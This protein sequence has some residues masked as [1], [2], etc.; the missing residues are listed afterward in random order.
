VKENVGSRRRGGHPALERNA[1]RVVRDKQAWSRVDGVTRGRDGILMDVGGTMRGIAP[2]LGIAAGV[3]AVGAAA[4][5]AAVRGAGE[6]NGG[7]VAT[8]AGM[9]GGSALIGGSLLGVVATPIAERFAKQSLKGP[10]GLLL[11]PAAIAGAAVGGA[12]ARRGLARTHADEYRAGEAATDATVAETQ[13]MFRRAGASEDAIA[14]VPT[15]YDRSFFNAQYSPPL[16]PFGKSITVG[17][18]PENG[19]TLAIND[20]IAHEFSH[21]VVDAYAPGMTRSVTGDGKAM[22]E[23]LADTFSMAV[24]TDDWLQGEDSW[25]GGVRSFSNPEERGSVGMDGTVKPAPITRA[26][27]DGHN[28][29]P[30]LGAGVGNKAAWRI[31]D[32]LGRDTMARIYVAALQRHELGFGSSYAT[33]AHATRAAAADLYGAGSHEAQV[34]D[35]SWTTAGY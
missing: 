2:L 31:G 10:K 32:A 19:S 1:T 27:L 23:S 5:Y 30:H 26:E 11:I 25:P 4:S 17:R 9:L 7:T 28:V 18:N 6:S 8:Y 13:A 29:E 22:H 34:V 14:S 3:G 16:G 15:R 21:K 33:L 12:L 24:D 20:V 35:A